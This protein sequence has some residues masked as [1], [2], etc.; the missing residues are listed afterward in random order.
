MTLSMVSLAPTTWGK[1]GLAQR[2]NFVFCDV[3]GTVWD[4]GGLF[5][6]VNPNKVSAPQPQAP[7]SEVYLAQGFNFLLFD[8]QG[9]AWGRFRVC[10][11]T[12]FG[13]SPGK[14]LLQPGYCPSSGGRGYN[15]KRIN[16]LTRNYYTTQMIVCR[17]KNHS[18]IW[19]RNLRFTSW[20]L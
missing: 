12:I 17:K 2:L 7:W 11:D 13:W 16:K 14:F 18:W 6:L 3:W 20:I 4:C 1:Q 5:V 19:T 8:F 10:R 15:D 9:T